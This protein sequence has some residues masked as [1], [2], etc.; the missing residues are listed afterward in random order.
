M[1]RVSAAAL[2]HP[3][4]FTGSIAGTATKNRPA[5][6]VGAIAITYARPELTR[7]GKAE[8][9]ITLES[10]GEVLAQLDK[11]APVTMVKVAPVDLASFDQL[12]TEMAVQQ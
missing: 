3:R 11:I 9:V 6:L 12:Y 7:K 1:P 10:I 5:L 2:S 8:A 4:C